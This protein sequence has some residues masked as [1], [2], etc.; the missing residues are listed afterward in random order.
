METR[1]RLVTIH[2]PQKREDR[3][4][5]IDIMAAVKSKTVWANV[6]GIAVAI[7]AAFGV[8]P[9]MT[10]KVLEYSTIALGIINLILRSRGSDPLVKK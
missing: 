10:G 5:T 2:R 3:I 9:E 4:M 6:L 7:G 8:S 1:N